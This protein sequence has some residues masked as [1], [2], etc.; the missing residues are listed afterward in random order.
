MAWIRWLFPTPLCPTQTRFCRLLINSPPANVS[1][2]TRSMTSAFELP[3]EVG[4]GLVLGEPGLADALG[5]TPL[6]A[7]VGLLV[8]QGPQEFQVRHPLALGTP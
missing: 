3:I 5:E 4:Q 2:R 1:I 7:S 6:A 8:D